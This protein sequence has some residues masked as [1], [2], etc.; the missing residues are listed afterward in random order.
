MQNTRPE[1]FINLEYLINLSKT[2]QKENKK[3]P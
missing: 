3:N 1:Y 2:E